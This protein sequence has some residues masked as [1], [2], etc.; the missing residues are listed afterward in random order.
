[1]LLRR[2]FLTGGVVLPSCGQLL[3]MAMRFVVAPAAPLP[4]R[5]TEEVTLPVPANT[6]GTTLQAPV[7][8]ITQWCNMLSE[9][10]TKVDELQQQMKAQMSGR[11]VRADYDQRRHG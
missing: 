8:E 9:C 5:P 3:R 6:A 7:T 2:Q 10:I 4:S 1:M 11:R